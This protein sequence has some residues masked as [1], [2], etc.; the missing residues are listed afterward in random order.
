LFSYSLKNHNL[1]KYQLK[2][3]ELKLAGL[4]AFGGIKQSAW[5]TKLS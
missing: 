2:M 5:K 4:S 3:M 1:S